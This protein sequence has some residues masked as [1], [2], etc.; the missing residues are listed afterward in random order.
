M[1]DPKTVEPDA[2]L[3][4]FLGG[5]DEINDES[6]EEDLTEVLARTEIDR[7]AKPE[8]PAPEKSPPRGK[9]EQGE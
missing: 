1:S 7:A 8:K 9:D 5:I 2:E 4:E 6:R 3:L